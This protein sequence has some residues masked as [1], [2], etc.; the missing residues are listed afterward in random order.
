M[1][2]LVMVSPPAGRSTVLWAVVMT[3]L[4]IGA[5]IAVLTFPAE[6]RGEYFNDPAFFFGSRWIEQGYSTADIE[7]ALTYQPGFFGAIGLSVVLLVLNATGVRHAVAWR[8]PGQSE[9]PGTGSPVARLRFLTDASREIDRHV[10]SHFESHGYRLK[11]EKPD[12]WTFQRGSRYAGIFESDIRAFDTTLTV[13][14]TMTPSDQKWITCLWE[15]RTFGAIFTKRD[16]RQLES[17]GQE[18]EQMLAS[19][20][21]ATGPAEISQDP[22]AQAA[23]VTGS[24][25][26]DSGSLDFVSGP[27]SVVQVRASSESDPDLQERMLELRLKGPV[28][29]LRIAAAVS[30]LF[31]VC[32]GGFWIIDGY[33]PYLRG[34][35]PY[36]PSLA[37]DFLAIG[38]G[39]VCLT[40]VCGVM[41]HGAHH[42]KRRTGFPWAVAAAGIAILPWHF[43]FLITTPLGI[44]ALYVLLRPDVRDA[45]LRKELERQERT[46]L[47]RQQQSRTADGINLDEVRAEID[48][49]AIGLIAGGFLLAAGHIITL[50]SFA[51]AGYAEPPVLL[52]G[53]VVGVMMLFAGLRMRAL[54]SP[55]IGMAGAVAALCP[56]S[57]GSA[58]TIPIGI[59]VIRTL[60]RPHVRRAFVE[61]MRQLREEPDSDTEFSMG[62]AFIWWLACVLIF[63]VLPVAAGLWWAT[64]EQQS[65]MDHLMAPPGSHSLEK[66]GGEGVRPPDTH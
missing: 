9:Q 46:E 45:F 24:S 53:V 1:A 5:L 37:E 47:I 59:V 35:L 4:A 58:I 39:Y 65:A 8:E 28:G 33:G 51:T 26:Q 19:E 21:S 32:F 29:G 56:V 31:W 48:G 49:P 10:V 2:V 7:S 23:T 40:V 42:M 27:G 64:R 13:R 52:F 54:K 57:P 6:A 25:G 55:G 3:L 11:Q 36:H 15:V 20:S 17:E 18:L 12:A 22:A 63:I 62:W 34:D 61:R 44:W 16:V 60:N 66:P 41:L 50:V 43:A 14:A 30:V 38:F